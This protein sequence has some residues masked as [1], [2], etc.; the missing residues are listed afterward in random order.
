LNYPCLCGCGQTPR[1]KG[2][3]FVQGHQFRLKEYQRKPNPPTVKAC[4]GCSLEFIAPTK[5]RKTQKYCSARCFGTAQRVKRI[6]R[7]CAACGVQFEI[8]PNRLE[9]GKNRGT[10]CS[11]KCVIADWNKKMLENEAP[12]SY[13]QRAWKK[14]ERKCRDC[15]YNEHPEILLIH[16]IDGNRNHGK[17][18][19]LIPLCQ[20]CHCL[21]HIAMRGNAKIPSSRRHTI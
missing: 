10:Y 4:V 12:N 2:A 3:N 8:I 9:P 19:N 16:H 7:V 21:R 15:G 20:N 17:L 13:R 14:F 18:S 1:Y 11:R 5:H 6:P